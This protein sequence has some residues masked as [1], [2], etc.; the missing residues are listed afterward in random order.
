M[1]RTPSWSFNY[2]TRWRTTAAHAVWVSQFLAETLWN[3]KSGFPFRILYISIFCFLIPNLDVQ[4]RI[5]VSNRLTL[6]L[7]YS[8]IRY[9]E[10]SKHISYNPHWVPFQF[11]IF[12]YDRFG[13]VTKSLSVFLLKYRS[14][15]VLNGR[16]PTLSAHQFRFATAQPHL[17]D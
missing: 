1:R 3:G 2:R 6:A 10:T 9:Y 13:F 14:P 12:T 5:Y 11:F 7:G 16:H 17:S 8:Y 4:K 15:N